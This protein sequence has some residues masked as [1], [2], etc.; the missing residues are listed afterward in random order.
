MITV[1]ETNVN[2]VGNGRALVLKSK[3]E[4]LLTHD[5]HEGLQS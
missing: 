3:V 1:K 5:I 4:V 2:L